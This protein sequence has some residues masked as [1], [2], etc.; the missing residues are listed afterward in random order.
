MNLAIDVGNSRVKAG[1]FAAGALRQTWRWDTLQTEELFALATNQKVK[2]IILSNVGQAIPATFERRLNQC[3][4]YLRLETDTPLPIENHYGTPETL[5]KD[6]L[7]AAAGAFVVFGGANCLIID[8]GTCITYDVLEQPGIFRG[9][10]I[11]PG[12]HMRLRAMHAFTANLPPA[13][14]ADT[15]SWI[16]DSTVNAM[17]NGAQWGLIH[18]IEGFIAQAKAAFGTLNVIL[19]GGDAEYLAKRLKSKIF[20]NQHLALLGLNKILTHNVERVD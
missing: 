3:F 10:N 17:R 7:A 13:A 6:R 20:V 19:T 1:L 2:N 4:T 5:G 11:A 8:A 18:E 12:L 14:P 16:G 15:E 9:G